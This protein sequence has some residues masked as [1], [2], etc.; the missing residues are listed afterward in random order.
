MKQFTPSIMRE[1]K[2]KSIF[3]SRKKSVTIYYSAK[4]KTEDIELLWI[5][6]NALGAPLTYPCVLRENGSLMAYRSGCKESNNTMLAH[7]PEIISYNNKD[8]F[9]VRI[10]D[11]GEFESLYHEAKKEADERDG[12]IDVIDLPSDDETEWTDEELL[13][14]T[15]LEV[16]EYKDAEE[17]T[18]GTTV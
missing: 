11:E 14:D 1:I 9:N 2:K 6:M 17:E 16:G 13:A 18:S 5:E 3:T 4:S 12:M 10:L 15:T 7:W 8:D